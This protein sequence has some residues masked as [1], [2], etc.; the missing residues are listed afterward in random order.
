M[1]PVGP[2]QKAKGGRFPFWARTA[3][4]SGPRP[5]EI[6]SVS[7]KPVS[8]IPALPSQPLRVAV[9]VAPAPSAWVE[10]QSL[11]GRAQQI[12]RD[13]ADRR[14]IR[15][16]QLRDYLAPPPPTEGL[17]L[18][19]VARVIARLQEV[20]R[21]QR[22]VVI[23]GD[24]DC[25]GITATAMLVK[26]FRECTPLQV[27]WE[28]PNRHRDQYGLTLPKAEHLL[29]THQPDLLIALDCGTN[30]AA[31]HA[32]LQRHGVDTL[33]LDHH[34]LEGNVDRHVMLLNPKGSPTAATELRELCTAGLVLRFCES[35][36]SAWDCAGRWDREGAVALAGLGT[37][38]DACGLTAY[39]RGLIKQSL[40]LLNTPDFMSRHPGLAALAGGDD[41]GRL[42]QR[43][44]QF[45]IIPQL[46][47][48]GRLADAG[49]GVELLL[50]RDAAQARQLAA[51]AAGLNQ[52]RKELQQRMVDSAFAQARA[53]LQEFPQRELLVLAQAD[54]HHG[55]VGPAA[56]R[57]VERF[58]RS[59]LL[60]ASDGSGRWRGSGRA[61]PEHDLG[62]LVIRLKAEGRLASG[63][64]HAAAVGVTM[65]S[66]HLQSL[67]NAASNLTL[68]RR[69]PA[70]ATTEILGDF[71]R[72]P[73]SEW[74]RIFG[75]LEPFGPGNPQPL[76]TARGA[77]LQ[78]APTPLRCRDGRIWATRGD[79]VTYNGQRLTVLARDPAESPA[80][81]QRNRDYD[82]ELE[83][84]VR[85]FEGRTYYNWFVR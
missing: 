76:L 4:P 47:A 64:G 53:Q 73:A 60:L 72:L 15:G 58:H 50:T 2:E 6:F 32:F 36:A 71:G 67:Q 51:E 35:L 18:P 7:M 28:L 84:G 3:S 65:T 57:V 19:D 39:H 37:L 8:E 16:T 61:Q 70:G 26:F 66:A 49:P 55:I 31:S 9:E 83:L 25:D 85:C 45:Q 21:L 29:K 68:P 48:L 10:F 5:G 34:P 81:W 13:Y 1:N 56:S 46:N 24:Y 23:F 38:G 42:D 78:S 63:G 69:A 27:R 12:V 20:R 22:R 82:F 52:L 80:R 41:T 44:V 54:W 75:L 17:A 33:V 40:A 62:A 14:G 79:F 30:S 74:H 11:S 77:H 59:A 43:Q